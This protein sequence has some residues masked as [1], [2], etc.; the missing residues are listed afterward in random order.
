MEGPVTFSGMVKLHVAFSGMVKLLTTSNH[1]EGYA[2]GTHYLLPFLF[3]AWRG[4]ATGSKWE[5]KR[6]DGKHP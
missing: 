4:L 1:L 5:L 6:E 2:R 3:F